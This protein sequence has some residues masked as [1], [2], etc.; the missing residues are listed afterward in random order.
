MR[1]TY[2]RKSGR[3]IY[4]RWVPVNTF[5]KSTQKKTF[6]GTEFEYKRCRKSVMIEEDGFR[7]DLLDVVDV[8]VDCCACGGAEE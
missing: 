3:F 1:G 6:G 2:T 7:I 8:V 4:M 5:L